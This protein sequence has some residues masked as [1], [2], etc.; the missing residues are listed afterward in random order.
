MSYDE[1]KR[2][3]YFLCCRFQFPTNDRAFLPSVPDA[4]TG[5]WVARHPHRPNQS[6]QRCSTEPSTS[7]IS[8]PPLSSSV[9]LVARRTGESAQHRFTSRQMRLSVLV[10]MLRLRLTFS[11]QVVR[12]SRGPLLIISRVFGPKSEDRPPAQPRR[13]AQVHARGLLTCIGQAK[14]RQTGA[15]KG[16]A[17][18]PTTR[19]E[20]GAR[21][22][23]P[24]L[25]RPSG[26]TRPRRVPVVGSNQRSCRQPLSINFLPFA[27][28]VSLLPAAPTTCEARRRW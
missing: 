12:V 14:H 6:I 4:T 8:R 19:T 3:L 7:Q 23:P 21:A 13:T 1:V 5:S 24:S 20:Q 18:L 10:P 26:R 11:G 27:S 2:F 16:D 15:A 17:W 9:D 22:S 25:S 28:K